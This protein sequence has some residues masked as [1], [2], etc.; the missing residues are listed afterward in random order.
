[1]KCK[2][3]DDQ[4][5]YEFVPKFGEKLQANKEKNAKETI[6]QRLK[7]LTGPIKSD[8]IEYVKKNP[9]NMKM[10]RFLNKQ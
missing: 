8:L 10:L 1:M 9:R 2:S 6:E 3:Q 5:S 7:E 4:T